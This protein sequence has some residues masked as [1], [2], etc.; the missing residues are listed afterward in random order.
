MTAYQPD[1]TFIGHNLAEKAVINFKTAFRFLTR[2]SEV[3]LERR[4]T[5]RKR[6][7]SSEAV[8]ETNFTGFVKR[9][10]RRAMTIVRYLLP[11]QSPW[12][13]FGDWGRDWHVH[14][15]HGATGP[16]FDDWREPQHSPRFSREIPIQILHGN[17]YQETDSWDEWSDSDDFDMNTNSRPLRKRRYDETITRSSRLPRESTVPICIDLDDGKKDDSKRKTPLRE[18][19]IKYSDSENL[20]PTSRYRT[21]LSENKLDKPDYVICDSDTEN[22]INATCDYSVY[23]YLKAFLN[24][25]GRQIDA[26]KGDGNCFF[27]ALSKVI[28]GNQSF[29]NEIRQ[30]VV[31]VLEEYPKKF[32]AF[33]DGPMSQHIRSMREDKTWATQ[34]EIYAAATL[35]NRDVYIL[36]PDQTGETYRWLLFKPQFKYNSSV[37]GCK[38]Y[39]TICHTHGNHYDR[40]APLK[41]KE[42]N[43]GLEPPEMSGVKGSV[44]LTSG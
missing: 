16:W 34:T 40:I 41:S 12:G 9:L 25:T 22:D 3:E 42:C 23:E 31:D 24:S 11:E 35:L 19:R 30:G 39:I 14:D 13:L 43:C 15:V 20:S 33:A 29:Y 26:I 21:R 10:K 7:D 18:C 36:S 6:S 4:G 44:D 32:E 27:R 38:C 8:N 5:K 28:Y 17:H 1:Q 37:T 2:T